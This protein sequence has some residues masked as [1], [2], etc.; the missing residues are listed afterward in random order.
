MLFI[1]LTFIF[2]ISQ[3]SDNNA[4]TNAYAQSAG[5]GQFGAASLSSSPLSN[6]TLSAAATAAAGKQV[7]G[8]RLVV[9][10][11]TGVVF[12]AIGF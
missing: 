1:R 12:A 11:H 4:L 10:P 5:L 3:G 8:K 2:N 9:E 6:V 7:E